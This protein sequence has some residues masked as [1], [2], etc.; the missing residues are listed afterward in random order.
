MR[1]TRGSYMIRCE[2]YDKA[3]GRAE[4]ELQGGAGGLKA[5]DRK[6]RLEEEARTKVS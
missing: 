3:R 6:K 5:L 1:K 2:E 4:E